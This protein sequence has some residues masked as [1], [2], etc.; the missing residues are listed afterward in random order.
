M[1]ATLRSIAA[2]TCAA[3]VAASLGA[4]VPQGRSAITNATLTP[5][6][7]SG[8]TVVV[9]RD[10][11]LVLSVSENKLLQSAVAQLHATQ[12]EVVA[13]QSL[14][15]PYERVVA[16]CT[17][18]RTLDAE[19]IKLQ[20]DQIDDYSDLAHRLEKLKNPW[21]TWEAGVGRDS[22]GPAFVAGV[23]LKRLRAWT[24]LQD[25]RTGWFL[26]Y[27]GRVF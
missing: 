8:W 20:R 7:D 24:S 9:G 25:G 17:N 3:L 2:A 6:G 11:L 16:A 22:A 18:A 19:V 15:A 5:R 13:L 10:T 21:M 1:I 26:G 23:G 12:D 27:S 4:Q 14:K